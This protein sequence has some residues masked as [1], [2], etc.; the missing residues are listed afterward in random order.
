MRMQFTYYNEDKEEV[1]VYA[2]DYKEYA[3]C[4][5]Q[6]AFLTFSIDV[7]QGHGIFI[8]SHTKQMVSIGTVELQTK[9]EEVIEPEPL[10]PAYYNEEYMGGGEP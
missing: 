10:T 5:G 9:P 1:Y 6:G 8:K 4:V 2:H 7:P 3:G